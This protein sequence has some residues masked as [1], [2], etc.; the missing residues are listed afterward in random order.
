[1]K[2]AEVE[3]PE[4]VTVAGTETLGLLEVRFTTVPPEGAAALNVTVPSEFVPPTTAAGETDNETWPR[5]VIV[6]VAVADFAPEVAVMT[7][8]V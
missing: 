2:V 6:S 3:P 1:M 8:V 4:T 5:L 7:A